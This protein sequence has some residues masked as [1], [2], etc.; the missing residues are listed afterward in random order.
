MTSLTC[1][2]HGFTDN[3]GAHFSGTNKISQ[4]S[5]KEDGGPEGNVGKG[6]EEAVLGGR[7]GKSVSPNPKH[8]MPTE[9]CQSYALVLISDPKILSLQILHIKIH[10]FL[11]KPLWQHCLRAISF[12]NGNVH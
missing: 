4:D 3:L 11:E 1:A 10:T 7:Q 6:R 12:S 5:S 8:N 2:V 9:N